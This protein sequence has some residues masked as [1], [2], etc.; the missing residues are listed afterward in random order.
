MVIVNINLGSEWN[1]IVCYVYKHKYWYN[2]WELFLVLYMFVSSLLFFRIY[3]E[4][5]LCSDCEILFILVY[6][7]GQLIHNFKNLMKY[8]I[9]K[10][11]FLT[12]KIKKFKNT[13]IC[14][15]LTIY[16][17][18]IETLMQVILQYVEGRE[19]VW[20]EKDGKWG[21][22]GQ[23]MWFLITCAIFLIKTF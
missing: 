23:T 8:Y 13:R 21:G 16:Q 10:F 1:I 22:G 15:L 7:V 18:I 6:S 12:W 14:H 9:L 2:D 11:W 17:I 20:P 4:F 5:C 3:V 19:A